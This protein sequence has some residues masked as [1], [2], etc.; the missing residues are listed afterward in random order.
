MLAMAADPLFG[1]GVDVITDH[2]N[3]DA[4][5]LTAA[6]IEELADLRARFTGAEVA[7]SAMVVGP[8]SPTRYGLGRMFEAYLDSHTGATIRIFETL[9]EAMS[10]LRGSEAEPNGRS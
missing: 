9:E 5:A 8:S 4:S 6:D 2:T 3:I 1:P 7:H 10:W